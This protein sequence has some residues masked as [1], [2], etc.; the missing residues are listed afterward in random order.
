MAK[1]VEKLDQQES[2]IKQLE[3]TCDDQATTIQQ[4]HDTVAS[5]KVDITNLNS[6][7]QEKEKLLNSWS[8]TVTNGHDHDTHHYLNTEVYD[9]SP[10]SSQDS[11]LS[12]DNYDCGPP[13]IIVNDSSNCSNSVQELRLPPNTVCV[14]L[15]SCL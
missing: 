11:I 12:N 7:L 2:K 9:M 8:S 5:Q 4:L 13:P 1:L 15:F 10:S 6:K 14:Y 3:L